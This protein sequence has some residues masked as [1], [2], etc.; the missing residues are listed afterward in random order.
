[1]DKISNQNKLSDNLTK[2]PKR[3]D[4][5]YAQEIENASMSHVIASDLLEGVLSDLFRDSN[6][7]PQQ[8]SLFDIILGD[9][10]LLKFKKDE[11][12]TREGDYGTSAFLIVKGS[13][14]IFHK[15]LPQYLLG[16]R[17]KVKP[18]LFKAF[19]KLFK[20]LHIFPEIRKNITAQDASIKLSE[21]NNNNFLRIQD[22]PEHLL[23][24]EDSSNK[25]QEGEIFGELAA[26]GRIPRSTTVISK[27]D[28]TQ[29]LEIRWQGL[30]DIRKYSPRFRE[31]INDLYRKRSLKIFLKNCNIIDLKN[32]SEDKVELIY[33]NL[34]E[35]VQFL[36]FG[37]FEWHS[38]YKQIVELDVS[39]RIKHEQV[40]IRQ[41]SH[42]NGVYFIKNGFGRLSKK[43]NYGEKTY[44]YL[45]K[46]HF[47]GLQEIYN[48]WKNSK[49]DSKNEL[50]N[51]EFTLRALGYLEII[52][53]PLPI[54]EKIILPYLD[55]KTEKLL[56]KNY[57]SNNEN[58]ADFSNL[59]P[60]LLEFFV[61]E[62]LLNGTST[63]LID[64]NRCT[65]C[66]DCVRACSATHDNNP[67][68]IRHGNQEQGIQFTHSCIHC[69]DPLCLIGCPTGAIHRD[70]YGNQVVINDDTCIGCSTCANNCPYDNIQM[71][72]PRTSEGNFYPQV[73]LKNNNFTRE[74]VDVNFVKKATKCDMCE[75]Y[76]TGPSCVQACPHDA[77]T[78]L[79]LNE[80]KNVIE[81]IKNR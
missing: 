65:R 28:N 9:S 44:S 4:V 48:N 66:D 25:S 22:T 41:D 7:F 11:I 80:P 64:L 71:V 72:E 16:R 74:E 34:I 67:R 38:D 78:R 10:R 27:E 3:W 24:D 56:E 8:L 70:Q 54:V 49:N 45:N 53:I 81:W 35:S 58:F 17:K 20:R 60:T 31:K 1:M 73:S 5:A 47:Y 36:T 6:K 39:E 40:I 14:N 55:D 59:D 61:Q 37:E 19:F 13:V 26:L 50:Q 2:K 18:S 21:S 79:N 43:Y 63:M 77:L 52:Y 33:N 15:H 69:S 75:T 23:E 42:P 29:I 30:R 12:I 62:R 68:F 32:L 76:K 46:G 51:L 57:L